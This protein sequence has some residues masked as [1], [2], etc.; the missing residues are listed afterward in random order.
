MNC[1]NLSFPSSWS[2]LSD[3][4][5]RYLFSLLATSLS[6]DQ[7]K[8]F[9]LFRWNN[10]KVLSKTGDGNFILSSLSP[11]SMGKTFVVSPLQIAEIYPFLDWMGNFPEYPVRVGRFGVKK[12]L[13]ADFSGVSF[14]KFIMADNLYQGF[15]YTKDDALLDQLGS[16]LY[17]TNGHKLKPWQRVNVF[18][19]FASL[20]NLLS[21]RFPDFFVPASGNTDARNNQVAVMNAMIRA[22][23]KGD[24]SKEKEILAL[25][26]WRA[27][28]ELNAQC[29]EYR[30]FNA[31]Y[32]KK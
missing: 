5:L 4:R 23:T 11:K 27:L 13:P 25:D 6:I 20:K 8:I 18:Y 3:K 17:D 22:L 14:E 7:V 32:N 30:E 10:L 12:A 31:K 26:C 15:L 21:E 24:V 28:E 19:W 16:V 9:C 2:D 29:R 1:L